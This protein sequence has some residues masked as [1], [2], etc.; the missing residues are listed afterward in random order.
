MEFS[1]SSL[2]AYWIKIWRCHCCGLGP[3]EPMPIPGQGNSISHGHS[4]K[5]KKKK[6]VNGTLLIVVSPLF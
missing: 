6:N 3:L 2:V 1:E 5:K 4:K